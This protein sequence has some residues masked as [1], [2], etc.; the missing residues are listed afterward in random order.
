M[1]GG[2]SLI[3]KNQCL[4]I[5]NKN[6]S[7]LPYWPRKGVP[8]SVVPLVEF[9]HKQVGPLTTPRE[10]ALKLYTAPDTPAAANPMDRNIYG[11][12]ITDLTKSQC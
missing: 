12:Q 1:S 8:H 2:L 9:F 10:A 3:K 4:T 7:F 5:S 6:N 11:S